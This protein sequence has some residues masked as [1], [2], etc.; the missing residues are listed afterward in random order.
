M[1]E[2]SETLKAAK[3]S[4]PDF[5]RPETCS[6]RAAGCAT[7]VPRFETDQ[8]QGQGASRA[9]RASQRKLVAFQSRRRCRAKPRNLS[10]AAAELASRCNGF[11]VTSGSTK[12]Q[13]NALI[14]SSF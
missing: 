13:A 8:K 5:D 12:Q 11:Y 1:I 3:V 7:S 2:I 9:A 6:Q 10:F 4:G 14:S